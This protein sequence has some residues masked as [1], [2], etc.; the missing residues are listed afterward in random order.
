MF[1]K[2]MVFSFVLMSLSFSPVFAN[3]QSCTAGNNASCPSGCNCAAGYCK[4]NCNGGPC[5]YGVCN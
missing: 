1:K 4:G 5:P 3:G 2:L